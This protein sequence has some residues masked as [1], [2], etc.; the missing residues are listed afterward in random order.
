MIDPNETTPGETEQSGSSASTEQEVAQSGQ[1]TQ[2]TEQ[3]EIPEKF[4]GKSSA[5]IAKAYL[6]AE[7]KMREVLSE[8]AQLQR[9]R[10]ESS[11]RLYEL[12][13]AMHNQSRA[14]EQAAEADPF[15]DI[16]KELESDPQTAI[17]KLVSAVR[18]IPKK[19]K[20][21]VLKETR[22]Y[23]AQDVFS[24]RKAENPDFAAREQDMAKL[25]QRFGH[26]INPDRLNDPDTIEILDLMSRGQK[27]ST[28]VKEAE[29]RVRKERDSIKTEKRA[30]HSESANSQASGTPDKEVDFSKLSRD[31]Q[32]KELARL[33]KQLGRTDR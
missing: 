27:T 31:E 19:A 16:E 9:E 21:A 32:K 2:E 6:E 17:K 23:Q 25:A 13:A 12:Q 15:A 22:S 14:R 28:Y 4:K 33:E 10:D 24:R 1:R 8:R 7:A 20:E 5:D 30:A 26:L 18:D 3:S 29:D 11:Q